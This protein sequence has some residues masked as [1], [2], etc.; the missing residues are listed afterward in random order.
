MGVIDIK[1]GR[2]NQQLELLAELAGK[3][4]PSEQTRGFFYNRLKDVDP[5]ELERAFAV[6]GERGIW[7]TLTQMLEEC[8]C[9][10]IDTRRQQEE[11]LARDRALPSVDKP[12]VPSW[13]DEYGELVFQTIKGKDRNELLHNLRENGWEIVHETDASYVTDIAQGKIKKQ[14]RIDKVVIMAR[15]YKPGSAPRFLPGSRSGE[16]PNGWVKKPVESIAKTLA[17]RCRHE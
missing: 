6:F 5:N 9:R 8:G 4:S 17:E 11:S 10:G 16:V 1:K 2:L 3:P 12:F 15:R 7:P 13:V 14:V